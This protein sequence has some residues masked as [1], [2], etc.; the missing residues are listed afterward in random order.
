MKKSLTN[1]HL[2]VN[3]HQK[4]CNADNSLIAN[5]LNYNM[6]LELRLKKINKRK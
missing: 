3:V 1:Y 5:E 4:N 2:F 6:N